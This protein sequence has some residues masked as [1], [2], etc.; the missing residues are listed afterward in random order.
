MQTNLIRDC[1]CVA[2]SLDAFRVFLGHVAAS[3][4][5]LVLVELI[6]QAS[7][8]DHFTADQLGHFR[9]LR[10]GLILVLGVSL[11]MEWFS[12]TITD[13]ARAHRTWGCVRSLTG[14]DLIRLGASLSDGRMACSEPRMSSYGRLDRARTETC[15]I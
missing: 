2:S 1:L 5:R 9:W 12:P 11:F 10:A 8:G 13:R 7:F 15:R 3:I 14:L 4:D 6:A